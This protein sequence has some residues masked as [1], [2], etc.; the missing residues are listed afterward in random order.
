MD[1]I[2]DLLN[3]SFYKRKSESEQFLFDYKLPILIESNG[4]KIGG[5]IQKR[6]GFRDG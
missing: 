4:F 3:I 1:L 2:E 5:F 6:A